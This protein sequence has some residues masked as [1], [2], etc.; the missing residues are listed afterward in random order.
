MA[1]KR[2]SRPSTWWLFA[3]AI[4]LYVLSIGPVVWYYRTKLSPNPLARDIINVIYTPLNWAD[5]YVPKPF[6]DVLM[7]SYYW[8][9]I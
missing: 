7:W 1:K 4:A 3:L 5:R 8:W 2:V 6:S 9:S